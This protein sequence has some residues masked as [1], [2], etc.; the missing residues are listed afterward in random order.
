MYQLKK[1][2]PET[3]EKVRVEN[4]EKIKALTGSELQ[5]K[6]AFEVIRNETKGF[7]QDNEKAKE[8]DRLFMELLQRNGL[9]DGTPS[10]DEKERI[11]IEA[12]A[13][14]RALALIELELELA[15]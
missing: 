3:L 5:P 8:A 4:Q 10:P 11:R 13:R 14:A 2:K 7:T 15:A 12:A 1:I 9:T 6:R